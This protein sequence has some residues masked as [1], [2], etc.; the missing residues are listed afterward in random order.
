MDD[1]QSLNLYNYVLNN[2]TTSVDSDGHQCDLNCRWNNDHEI[3]TQQAPGGSANPENSPG[4]QNVKA[5]A[6][7]TV[8][9]GKAAFDALSITPYVGEF[10]AA[11][12]ALVSAVQG[13]GQEAATSTLAAI[14]AAGLLG[15]AGKFADLKG[16]AQVGDNIVAHHMPQA[17]L[18]FTS[19]AEGGAL[20]ITQG[21]HVA[22]R[23]FGFKGALTAAAD[24]GR[25]FRQVLA[26]DIRDIRSIAGTKYNEGLQSLVKYYKDNVPSLMSK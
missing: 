15:K 19:K 16:L 2:P 12:S 6:A 17:A 25:G 9:Y 20:A 5:E 22:T 11:G 23:T 18:G 1:P 13:D 8:A 7:G 14:P 3:A 21:E 4:L 10:F 24:A 26:Q